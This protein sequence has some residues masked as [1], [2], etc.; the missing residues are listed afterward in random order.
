M[1]RINY[2]SPSGKV[3]EFSMPQVLDYCKR[4]GLRHVPVYY[5]GKAKDA[6][7]EIS[8]E[9]HWHENFL[10]R[11]IEDYLEKDDVY[12]NNKGLPDEGI[13]LSKRVDVFEGLKLKSFR[14]LSGESEQ[15]DSGEGNIEDE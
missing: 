1:F 2:T 13:V 7:P 15:L 8:T 6:Y 12:C 3:Y 4:K 14:F 10:A 5:I 11:L 9:E